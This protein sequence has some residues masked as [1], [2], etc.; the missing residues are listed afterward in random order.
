MSVSV[1]HFVLTYVALE[2]SYRATTELQN[3][4]LAETWRTR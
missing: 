3:I 2:F 1:K 4:L